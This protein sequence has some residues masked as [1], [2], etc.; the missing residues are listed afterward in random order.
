[1][2]KTLSTGQVNFGGAEGSPM[3]PEVS[4]LHVASGWEERGLVLSSPSWSDPSTEVA[5]QLL[6]WP[7]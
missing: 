5:T 1:M 4:K 6:P 3:S 7:L 2:K